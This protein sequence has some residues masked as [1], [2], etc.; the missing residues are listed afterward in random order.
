MKQTIRKASQRLIS[1][2]GRFC[3]S[4]GADSNLQRHHPIYEPSAVQILCQSC[5]TALHMAD[6]TWGKGPKDSSKY[7]RDCVICGRIFQANHSKLGKT[8]SRACLSE[9]GRLNASKRW[10]LQA[11]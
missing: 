9:L 3:A 5:H 8:C 2:E 10:H 7:I 6:G 4:C 11:E 1:L